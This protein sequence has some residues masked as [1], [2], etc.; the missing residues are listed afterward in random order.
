[1]RSY[2]ILLATGLFIAAITIPADAGG[3]VG[4]SGSSPRKYPASAFPL[5]Y[6]TDQGTLGKFSNAQAVGI[7]GYAFSQWDNIY[8]TTLSFI[9][10]GSLARDVTS[11]T[12]AYISGTAQYGDGVN[13]VV[14]DTDGSI[15]DA[16]LGVGAKNSVLGFAGSAYN[17]AT[18][19]YV[20]GYAIINGFLS[21]SATTTEEDTYK[22]TMTHEIGHFLGLG[23]SQIGLHGAYPTMYPIIERPS[24]QKILAADDTAA[25]AELYP[26]TG[27]A[28][29]VGTIKGTVKRPDGTL[30]SGVNVIAMN[31]ATHAAYSSVVDYFSGGSGGFAS[32]PTATGIYAISGLPPGSYH[33]RIEP[34]NATFTSGSSIASYGVPINTS[35]AQEWYNGGNESGDMLADNTNA[36]NTVTVTAGSTVGGI[37]FTANES[38]TTRVLSYHNGTFW[39]LVSLPSSSVTNYATRFTAPSGGSLVGVKFRLDPGSQLPANGTLTVS[40]HSNAA[41]SLAGVPGAV[42]GSVTIPFSDLVADQENIVYLRDIGTA[43]N[44]TSG[45]DFHISFS[46][47]GVGLLRFQIDNGNPTQNRSSFFTNT[48]GWRNMA[49]GFTAGYNL[50][51]NAIY[52]TTPVGTSAVVQSQPRIDIAPSAIDFGNL[53]IGSSRT[54]S[55][56]VTNTGNAPLNV[57]GSDIAGTDSISFTIADGDDG[58]TLAPGASH[59]ISI[60]FTPATAGGRNGES[61]TKSARLSITSN[62]PTS[63]NEVP[64]TGTG[65]KPVA[66]ASFTDLSF[67]KRRVGGVYTIDTVLLANPCNDTLHLESIGFTGPDA[68]AFNV[69]GGT[70]P[71]VVPPDGTHRIRIEFR[72]T[73]RRTYSATLHVVHDDAPSLAT[74]VLVTGTGIAPALSAPAG[75]AIDGVRVGTDTTATIVVHNV[76]DAPLRIDR[77]TLG[78]PNA[79]A[80][81][82]VSPEVSATSPIVVEP[83]ALLAIRVRFTPT[84][85][86]DHTALLLISS[87]DPARPTTEAALV[88]VGLQGELSA[89]PSTLDFGDA[90]VDSGAVVRQVRIVNVGTDTTTVVSAMIPESAFA[91]AAPLTVPRRLAPGDTLQ[92]GV[93]FRPTAPGTQNGTLTIVRDDLPD[94]FR[95]GLIGRGTRPG[96]ALDRSTIAFGV[97][98]LVQEKID[99]LVVANTGNVPL[100]LTSLQITGEGSGAFDVLSPFVPTTLAPS[101]SRSILVRLRPQ[102][103][104]GTYA[105]TLTIETRD[106]VTAQADLTATAATALLT[107]LTSVDFGMHEV[108]GSYDTVVTVRNLGTIDL[109]V[110]SIV[111]TSSKE[112]RDGNVGGAYFQPLTSAPLKIAAGGSAQIR[113][114]FMPNADTGV[115]RGTLMLFTN[116]PLEETITVALRGEGTSIGAP[117]SAVD[118]PIAATGES[119]RRTLRIYPNPATD[120]VD[121]GY[122]LDVAGPFAITITDAVGRAVATPYIGSGAERDSDRLR[123]G[124]DL[125]PSGRY[126][127]TLRTAQGI[128]TEK[129]V[130]VR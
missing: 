64:L 2:T 26:I 125:L 34:V 53:R 45:T 89:I 98:G 93:R 41:G 27:Y 100:T 28:A 68:S 58:F 84:A 12:D 83:T 126:Y 24:D 124:L 21:G 108:D 35:I 94:P 119:A 10:G 107:T 49:Q 51:V 5:V 33:V 55:V 48:G 30:L 73:A 86:G 74:D 44:F 105:A 14:F 72:P 52:S 20:E 110:D 103:A 87:D 50:L 25:M 96:L 75:L 37:D 38:S 129:L 130:V 128:T 17:T 91:L 39:G 95:V 123:L 42:L 112:E 43:I 29:R 65:V 13:P 77:L 117:I 120:V 3:P 40:V 85:P 82:I 11:A 109:R 80:F 118:D 9:N 57:T 1:M 61:A 60:T 101:E 104:A 90:I 59:T 99:S 113:V 8:S 79:D 19:N 122:A 63:P 71:G 6:K 32:P 23:H 88:G 22:A 36:H 78:G 16:K 69:V 47:N 66:S 46:T 67:G 62:A 18:N 4:A 102:N 15:T 97:I 116:S 56:T 121:I 54:E 114:I 127:V 31:T 76:G 111:T 81:A 115:Y 7:A 92:L 106:G 70:A